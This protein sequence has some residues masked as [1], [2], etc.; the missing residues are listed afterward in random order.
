MK[1]NQRTKDSVKKSS[2]KPDVS[3]KA[4][5]PKRKLK[6][7][8]REKYPKKAISKELDE[9]DDFKMN[10]EELDFRGDDSED[11][12]SNYDGFREEDY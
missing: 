9:F 11:D 7:E 6:P 3:G 10:D 4:T 1:A 2:K 5:E 12:N 8:D